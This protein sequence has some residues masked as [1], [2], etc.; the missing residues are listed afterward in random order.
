MWVFPLLQDLARGLGDL[1]SYE[2]NVEEDFYLTFQV[3]S[4]LPTHGM[5]SR[6]KLHLW[7]GSLLVERCDLSSDLM[8]SRRLL[9]TH[10]SHT[11]RINSLLHHR[12]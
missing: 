12:C 1:L 11:L 3:R 5:A 2:G 6:L 9:M 10:T 7:W 4:H 8:R